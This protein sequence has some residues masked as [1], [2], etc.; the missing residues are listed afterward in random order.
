MLKKILGLLC[1]LVLSLSLVVAVPVGATTEI[2]YVDD[3][4]AP[5]GNGTTAEL[6]GANCA[7]QTISA[8]I[9]AAVSGDT[10]TVAAGT[11][12]ENVNVNKSLTLTGASSATV[13]VTAASQTDS[14]FTVAANNVTISGFTARHTTMTGNEGYAGIKFGSGV[15][16]CNIHDNILIN[17]Q[18][19]ILL[20]DPENTT[21]PGNNTF[22]SNNASSNGVSGIEMQHSYGNTFTTN[23]T[24]SN[25][26]YGFR[27]DGVSHNT[28]TTNTASSNTVS[29]FSL[30]KGSSTGGCL[31]NT[32]TTNTANLNTQYGFREDNGD[33]NTLTGN[34]FDHNVL[35]GLRLKVVITNLTLNNNSFTNSPIGIDIDT[36]V[37]DV[38]T[39]AVSYNNITG[40]TVGVSNLGT[41]TLTALYNWWGNAS[42]PDDDANVINGSGDKISVN[43]DAKPW[44]ATAT[45]TPGRQYVTVTESPGV[46]AYSD[47][48]Q[49]GIGA[50]VAGNT[51]SVAAGTYTENVNVNKELTL[52]GASSATVTVTAA[53]QTVSVFYVTASSVNMSG[54]TVSGATGGGQAGIYLN[55]GVTLCDISHNILTDNYDGIWLGAGS[56]NN[57]LADNTLSN[58][59]QGFEVYHSDYNT[60]T[61]NTANSN[62]RY[63]FKM[64]SASYNTF[65]DN[66]ANSNARC[67][68]YLVTGPA[69]GSTGCN[70]NTF[71]NNTANSNTD[72]GIRT[73]GRYAY[74]SSHNEL[75]ENTFSSNAIG[76]AISDVYT[77]V[78]TWTVSYNNIA[79]NTIGVSN[80]GTDTLNALYNWWGDETG[81][82]HA[83]L[84][85]NAQGNAVSDNVNFSPWLYKPQQNF[86]SGA[87]CYAGSVVLANEATV[88]GA[89]SD[90]GWNSF[91]TPVT[92]AG[93]ANTWSELLVL[94]HDSGLSILRVQYFNPSTQ[95]WVPV[96]MNDTLVNS[97]YNSIAPGVGFFI[98]VTTKGSL[99]ILC[100]TGATS[101]PMTNLLAGWNL[102]GLSNL[103]HMTVADALH[104]ISYSVALSASPPNTSAW[105]VPP[106]ADSAKDL[107]L[108]EAYWVAMSEPGILFGFTT[109]PVAHDM[110]W[111]LN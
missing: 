58:N 17:N 11:Y 21:T 8:A 62:D 32:F 1:A 88:V 53:S 65:E 38:T 29:G 106:S 7:F 94:V 39:W 2:R 89:D 3:S 23:T 77:D 79:G 73:N 51:V 75:T 78:T 57:S 20:Q 98:Q 49:S 10:I 63:G 81:P 84:N 4:A 52:T 71:K 108:G 33:H 67:G 104:G 72:S 102:V 48:I 15:T 9:T 83:T 46:R 60:F 105:S 96:V 110:I 109:T 93:E 100:N 90:G 86:V 35:A 44:Y 43:V 18:Y 76:I 16:G 50:A 74:D 70:G 101:P 27:L 37:T 26:S 41:G 66:T 68:F 85:T 69:G 95:A 40:N 19:G 87:P 59:L 107:L 36:S 91:S 45:T 31:Y 34:T 80:L 22:T 61:G 25:G 103:T 12:I 64:E 54:F 24:N 13:T 28:F 30:V 99:P 14:V 56:D 5:S 47:T 92:L 6:A 111:E 97:T 55:A 42:G 82:S